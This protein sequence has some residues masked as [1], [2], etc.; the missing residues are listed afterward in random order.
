MNPGLAR[1]FSIENA[2][3]FQDYSDAELLQA[4]DWKLKAQDRTATDAAKKVAIEVLGRLR[5]R[6]NFGN[7]GEVENLLSRA[8]TNY[9]DRQSSVPVH[10]RHHNAPFEPQ[11][12]D[13][14]FDRDKNASSNLSKLFEDMIGA[15]E[16]IGK[17]GRWQKMAKV[18]KENGMDMQNIPTNFVFKG[19]PGATCSPSCVSCH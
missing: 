8:K 14:D 7:I 16:I 6:P 12:F 9:Q 2:F 10:Q 1:R 13:P 5:I 18:L 11:D 15:E 4:L 3:H 19:P 17:L